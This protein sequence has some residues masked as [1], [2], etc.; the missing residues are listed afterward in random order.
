MIY[1]ALRGLGAPAPFQR[2]FLHRQGTTVAPQQFNGSF[3]ANSKQAH[4]VPSG[5]KFLC[6]M[7]VTGGHLG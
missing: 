5:D 1:E 7:S 6:K 4:A 2:P 3:P